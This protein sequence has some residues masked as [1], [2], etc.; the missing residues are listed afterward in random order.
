MWQKKKN[1]T[2]NNKKLFFLKDMIC[3]HAETTTRQL[4]LCNFHSFSASVTASKIYSDIIWMILIKGVALQKS[5]Y[6]HTMKQRIHTPQ[7]EICK[8]KG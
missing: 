5:F 7:T 2:I 1:V 8:P 6:V 4:L 3:S